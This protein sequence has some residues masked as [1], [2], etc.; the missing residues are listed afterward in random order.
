MEDP[1][2]TINIPSCV[3]VQCGIPAKDVRGYGKQCGIEARYCAEIP[4]DSVQY[5]AVHF[6][7]AVVHLA[8][9]HLE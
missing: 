3:A 4:F 1:I 8:Y 7:R 5:G 6:E 9:W 2:K